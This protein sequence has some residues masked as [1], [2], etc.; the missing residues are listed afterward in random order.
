MS[1]NFYPALLFISLVL[2]ACNGKSVSYNSPE[3]ETILYDPDS[4]ETI[5]LDDVVQVTKV[6]ELMSDSHAGMIGEIRELLYTN[7]V[8]VVFDSENKLVQTFDE[9]GNFIRRISFLGN[10][11]HEYLDI[12]DVC[13]TPSGNI[14]ILDIQKQRILEFTVD[15]K[16]VSSFPFDCMTGEI[17][18]L[19]NDTV[20]FNVSCQCFNQD[21]R[22]N[23]CQIF[24]ADR[25]RNGVGFWGED[26]YFKT[27]NATYGM[28]FDQIYRFGG[29]VLC[30]LLDNNIIYKLA[31]DGT[32]V[33]KYNL[34]LR[35]DDLV[36]IW[37]KDSHNSDDMANWFTT[38]FDNPYFGG[39][40]IEFEDYTLVR[41]TKHYEYLPMLLYDHKKNQTF[42]LDESG[43]DGMFSMFY[44]FS[45]AIMDD[46]HSVVCWVSPDV[47][48]MYK[49]YGRIPNNELFMEAIKDY[50]E[51]SN[52]L[53]VVFTFK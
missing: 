46:G 7:G 41:Y 14:A 32:M 12:M 28:T 49:E 27:G 26:L 18:Y 25:N 42:A 51:E 2:C 24:L 40:F 37:D 50:T 16:F 35:P 23:N 34:K 11:P 15:G 3:A 48:R 53:L 9:N 8:F 5:R 31:D 36:P 44:N 30:T 22:I 38:F 52:P 17:E 4:T 45:P 19:N 13:I 10:G 39:S 20:V 6:I 43:S 29:S 47:I 1:K 33:P 21:D